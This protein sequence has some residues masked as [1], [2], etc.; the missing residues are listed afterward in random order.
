M[1]SGPATSS[2]AMEALGSPSLL[3]APMGGG[4]A[5]RILKTSVCRWKVQR[6]YTFV[7][8]QETHFTASEFFL[9]IF[10]CVCVFVFVSFWSC[11]SFCFCESTYYEK[12]GGGGEIKITTIYEPVEQIH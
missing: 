9:K 7:L 12:Q 8:L 10:D 5:F 3:R 6:Q 2:S 4:H 1:N 11:F